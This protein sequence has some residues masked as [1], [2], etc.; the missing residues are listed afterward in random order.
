[1]S[2]LFALYV[3]FLTLVTSVVQAENYAVIIGI[4]GYDEKQLKPLGEYPRND[5]VEFRDLLVQSGFKT[6]NII[7]MVDDLAALPKTNPAGRYLPESAKIRK[8][9]ELLL[10]TLERNDTLIIALAGHGVQ[11]KGDQEPFFCPLDAKLDDKTTLISL[12]WL[13]DQLKYDADKDTGCKPRQ[14]L[15]LVDACRNDPESVIRRT[16]GTGPGLASVTLPQM[17]PLPEGVVALFSCEEGQEALQHEPLKHGVFFY[18]VLQGW[19]G[20]ADA[21]MDQSVTLDE[22]IA[23]TKSGTQRYARTNLAS[24]QRP[25]QKGFFDGTWVLRTLEEEKL[26]TNTLGMKL[27]LIPSG[28]FLMGSTDADIEAVLKLDASLKKEQFADEQPQHRVRITKP[29]YLGVHEVTKGQFAAFVKSTGYQTDAE[30]DGKGG[31]GL[32]VEGQF[33]QKPEYSWKNNSFPQTDAHPVVNVSWNDAVAFCEWLSGKE[34]K[35]YKLPSEAEWEY[36]CRAGTKSLWWHGSDVEGLASVGNV[37]DGTAKEKFGSW[38]TIAA[39]DGYVF[40]SPVGRFRPNAFGLYDMSGNAYEWC[41]DGC[42][43]GEYA[44]RTGVTS[45]PVNTSAVDRRVLRGGSWFIF[46]WF[47]RSANRLRYTPENRNY[48]TGFRV[49]RT[50]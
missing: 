8:E 3:L 46:A 24:P 26:V 15:L 30:K 19:K 25:R 27:T 36:A 31:Y 11:F 10:P 1:M 6:E 43:E 45:D 44:T 2:R 9:L 12:N 14:K 38:K 48:L 4:G 20:S 23:Y 34:G 35:T 47:S 33:E 50:Q 21:D 49:S 16:G 17:A 28:E 5:A 13:Y 42:A 32:N 7:L 40:T 18:H 37:A 39:K 29:F 41:R 22:M